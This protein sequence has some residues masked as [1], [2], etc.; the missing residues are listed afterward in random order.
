MKNDR[1]STVF[2]PIFWQKYNQKCLAILGRQ[3]DICTIEK[4]KAGTYYEK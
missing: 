1:K 2:M 4:R 3:S